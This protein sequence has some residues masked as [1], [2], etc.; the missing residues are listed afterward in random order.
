MKR[1]FCLLLMLC[2]LTACSEE[3][4]QEAGLCMELEFAAPLTEGSEVKLMDGEET[5]LTLTVENETQTL[6][7]RSS[8]LKQ[9]VA[10]TLTVN[11]IVQQHGSDLLTPPQP[12][13]DIPDQPTIPMEPMGEQ[14]S[15]SA[16]GFT[17]GAGTQ[18]GMGEPPEGMGE[19][20]EGMGE[21][22]EGMGEGLMPPPSMDLTVPD[23]GR[24]RPTMESQTVFMLTSENQRFTAVRDAVRPERKEPN[25]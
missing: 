19:P 2:L 23:A 5:V 15:E 10:Y 7:L 20:P 25:A 24:P 22:P 14:P 12:I 21:P 1:I 8:A 18:S 17:P 16:G 13:E 9:N 4:P 3:K 11:G 6:T